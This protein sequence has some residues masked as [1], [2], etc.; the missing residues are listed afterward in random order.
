[1][2]RYFGTCADS[3]YQALLF[4]LPRAKRVHGYYAGKIGTGDEARDGQGQGPTIKTYEG[5]QDHAVWKF[6][7]LRP[8]RSCYTLKHVCIQSS[9]FEFKYN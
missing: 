6:G 5:P 4:F 3:V 2:A 1:M 7:P 8:M 9:R